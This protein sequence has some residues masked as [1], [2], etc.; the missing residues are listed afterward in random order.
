MMMTWTCDTQHDWRLFMTVTTSVNHDDWY[1]CENCEKITGGLAN[2]GRGMGF[3]EGCPLPNRSGAWRGL[4]PLP[5]NF[6]N[7]LAQNS[8]F[9]HLL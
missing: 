8:A 5:R 1:Q 6:F 4:C 2:M 3:G 9:W 7:F